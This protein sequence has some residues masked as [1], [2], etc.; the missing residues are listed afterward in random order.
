L[1][2]F[3]FLHAPIPAIDDQNRSLANGSTCKNEQ[4]IS[5]SLARFSF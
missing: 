4:R 2:L 5:A 3:D 1:H